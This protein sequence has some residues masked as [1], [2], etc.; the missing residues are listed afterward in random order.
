MIAEADTIMHFQGLCEFAVSEYARKLLEAG[1]TDRLNRGD[2]LHLFVYRNVR[3]GIAQLTGVPPDTSTVRAPAH[4]IHYQLHQVAT[5]IT[6]AVVSEY[7]R[8]QRI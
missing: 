7:F 5:A 4:G 1:I 2:T 6:N 3:A 8:H